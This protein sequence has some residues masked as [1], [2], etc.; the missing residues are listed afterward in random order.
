[1]YH[2]TSAD[3]NQFVPKQAGATFLS[4]NAKF[5]N[6]FTDQ[7]E[8]FL[9]KNLLKKLNTEDQ[10]KF[11]ALKKSAISIANK[12]GTHWGD[13]LE[14]LARNQLPTRANILPV[15]V[16]ATNPFDY[17][18]QKHL[19]ALRINLAKNADVR[20]AYKQVNNLMGGNWSEIES[21]A[22]Q[23]AIKGM[24]HDSFWVR[25]GGQKNLGIYDPNQIKSSIGNRGTYDFTNPDITKAEGGLMHLA[26]GGE[27]WQRSEGKNPEGGLNAKGRASYNK[28]HGA[29][30]KAPQPEGGSRK[31]SFC[32]RMSGMKKKLT[33][34]K[35]ANDPDSRI[36]KALRK[37]KC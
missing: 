20:D 13:E 25:E 22:V 12:N 26:G 2:G 37:W 6:D 23:Q 34:S 15:H 28:A 17:E 31:D 35:T 30:L 24:G 33:S 7:S 19:D 11:A 14:T 4:P 1:M 27:A 3:I 9:A 36:N 21:P 16:N 10:D 29:H 8:N 5:A 18:N 32:A